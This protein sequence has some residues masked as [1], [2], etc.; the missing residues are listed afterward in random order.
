MSIFESASGGAFLV[1]KPAGM[2]SAD[3]VNKIKRRFKLK[4]VGHAG[5][6]DPFATGLLVVLFGKATRLQDI[7]M[8]GTKEYRG[9]FLL[10]T[11]TSS[12]DITG[13]VIESCDVDP[14][15]WRGVAQRLPEVIHKFS[16]EISQVPPKVSAIKVDGQRSYNKARKG[17]DFELNARMV[18]IEQFELVAEKYTELSYRVVCSKGTYIR[19]LARDVAKE[20]GLP[21]CVKTLERTA[22]KPFTLKEAVGLQELLNSENPDTFVASFERLTEDFSH[23]EISESQ[24]TDLR[25][26]K[27]D[28][29]RALPVSNSKFAVL[30]DAAT[31]VIAVIE[32]DEDS[33][34]KVRFVI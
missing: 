23:F 19:S 30:R 28:F 27:Q 11:A 4:R 5:T 16:G 1:N 12:D 15:L 6:L 9:M 22:S 33:E 17:E 32:Q 13:E 24:S 18:T 21:G 7:F 8:S 34:W 14:E 29:L 2:T 31:K 20:L 25:L 3:V 10:G 26:G